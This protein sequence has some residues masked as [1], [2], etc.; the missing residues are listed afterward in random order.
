[1]ADHRPA[2][3]DA[4]LEIADEG[5]LAAVSMR[6]VAERVGLTPMALYPHVGGKEGL[7]DGLLERLLSEVPLPGPELD[8]ASRLRT[9][10]HGLRAAAARH[11]AVFGLLV[12]RPS[13]AAGSLLVIEAVFQALLA[14]GVPAAE[15]PR[16]E[17]LVSTFVIGYATSEVSGRFSAGTVD[18]R[19]RVGQLPPDE[20]PAHRDLVATLAAGIDADA[21]FAADLADLLAMVESVAVRA[22]AGQARSA[23]QPRTR[24]GRR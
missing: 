11:P 5:G 22:T 10:A 8:W 7:L 24:V 9:L 14:A 17:R 15:V 1:M 2:I 3:L 16:V 18:V 21:E 6:A 23:K 20:L 12:S 13:V 4:A 19:T